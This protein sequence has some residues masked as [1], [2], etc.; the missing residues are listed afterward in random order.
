MWDALTYVSSGITLVAFCGAIWAWSFRFRLTHLERLIRSAPEEAR[1]GLVQHAFLVYHIPIDTNDLSEK[2]KF[3]TVVE[4]L[5][6]KS[7]HSRREAHIYS[8]V[9]ILVAVV[10]LVAIWRNPDLAAVRL[11]E[12]RE[13]I[14]KAL[15]KV[16]ADLRAITPPTARIR[17][18]L[19]EADDALRTV[20]NATEGDC[21]KL[22]VQVTALEVL[23]DFANKKYANV[24]HRIP[25]NIEDPKLQ[26]LRANALLYQFQFPESLDAFLYALAKWPT[27]P[28]FR[29]G[30]L[31]SELLS[32][33]RGI[34]TSKLTVRARLQ[35]MLHE[36]DELIVEL[37][38]QP[39]NPTM[40]CEAYGLRSSIRSHLNPEAKSE[41]EADL[42][43]AADAAS[44][45][46]GG[47]SLVTAQIQVTIWHNLSVDCMNRITLAR[48]A[49]KPIVADDVQA[50]YK[51]GVE[52]CNVAIERMQSWR[53]MDSTFLD[54][55][56]A[57][58]YLQSAIL[59]TM[60]GSVE[61]ALAVLKKYNESELASS[62][63]V[64]NDLKDR[65]ALLTSKVT[66][67]SILKG[68]QLPHLSA[69]D[70]GLVRSAIQSVQRLWT[71]DKIGTIVASLCDGA[72]A[73]IVTD[74]G[75]STTDGL[76][77]DIG[78]L[79]VVARRASQE[80]R[81]KAPLV[82]ALEELATELEAQSDNAA[83][84]IREL[85]N[86]I[87]AGPPSQ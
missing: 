17:H 35:E 6:I 77:D 45:L 18:A 79:K 49:G 7:D 73:L 21:E 8:L 42:I 9:A 58:A 62:N 29:L 71:S 39:P 52:Y 26:I 80:S 40:R 20:A 75:M 84:Q 37:Q 65:L 70:A 28:Q 44:E 4:Q 78:M 23:P 38:R 68:Q 59:H 13:R 31:T 74:A 51:R 46:E 47:V 54:H 24:L 86:E 55:Q 43:Q 12:R 50:E 30:A 25:K 1:A 3:D 83:V 63:N 33:T 36:I 61:A 34:S 66:I 16:R 87:C 22:E 5:R 48:K 76:Q 81:V 2:H 72:I 85:H 14:S 82:A 15:E 57:D 10:A 60:A 11:K 53:E 32:M 69:L 67:D 56:L 64:P 19:E 27:D 41:I